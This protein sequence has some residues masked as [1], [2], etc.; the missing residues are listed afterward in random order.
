M[1][2][3]GCRAHAHQLWHMGL[4]APQ[5]VKS[6]RTRGQTH[7]SCIGRQILNLWTTREVPLSFYTNLKDIYPDSVQIAI[8]ILTRIANGQSESVS[9]SVMSDSL[10]S[11]RVQPTRLLCPGNSPGK[12]TGLGYHSFFQV[13]FLTQGSNP[14]LV[15]R[16]QILHRLNHRKTDT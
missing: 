5:Y 6:S 11:Y 1:F 9:Y 14:G 3:S 10:R 13:I 2:P 4:V 12:N 15:H 16:R 8:D 7:A